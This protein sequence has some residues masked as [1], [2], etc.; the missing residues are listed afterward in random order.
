MYD[1]EWRTISDVI[2]GRDQEGMELEI[3]RTTIQQEIIPEL[4]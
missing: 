4:T 3:L 2:Q 1:N